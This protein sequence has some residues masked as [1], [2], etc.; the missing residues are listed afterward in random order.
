M[1]RADKIYEPYEQLFYAVNLDLCIMKN[2]TK[3]QLGQNGPFV[4][5]LGLGC[6]RMSS[7][8][9][10]SIPE[11]K[12]S[13]ATIHEALN[14]GINFLNTGDFYGAG[15]NEFLLE[16]PLKESEKKLSSV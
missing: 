5:K 15:H 12:E 9:G 8:W 13:M 3:I 16:K 14:S 10:G 4:S 2:I 6:M 11:E 7:I 1:S